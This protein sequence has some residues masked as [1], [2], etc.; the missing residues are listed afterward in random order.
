MG[1]TAAGGPAHAAFL[2]IDADASAGIER[3]ARLSEE[4][5]AACG[6]DSFPGATEVLLA[7]G[8]RRP[9]SQVGVGR[10]GGGL[11]RQQRPGAP[12]DLG[13][14]RRRAAS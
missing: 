7:D 10:T 13:A 11:G 4:F 6:T 12:G 5:R 3:S 9:I 1:G 14:M 8:S 2:R